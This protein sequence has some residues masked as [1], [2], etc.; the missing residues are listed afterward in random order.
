MKQAINFRLSN[1]ALNTI[2]FLVKK[3]HCSKTAVIESALQ[4]YAKKEISKQNEFLKYAGILNSEDA[5]SMLK[6]IKSSKKNKNQ[7]I[8]L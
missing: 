1:Q 7:D 2:I 4:L 5:D 3:L 6:I 8:E